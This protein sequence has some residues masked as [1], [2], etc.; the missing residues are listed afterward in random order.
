MEA[1]SLNPSNAS[2][3]SIL[4][5]VKKFLKASL[6][7]LIPA[8]ASCGGGS[9]SP[10]PKPG[11]LTLEVPVTKIALQQNASATVPLTITR[12][13]FDGPV[14][15]KFVNA[16]ASP[17]PAWLQ[18]DP[19]QIAAGATTGTLTLRASDSADLIRNACGVALIATSPAS[20]S[21]YARSNVCVQVTSAVKP[22]RLDTGFADF[23]AAS[24]SEA[25]DLEVGQNDD[26]FVLTKKD[27]QKLKANGQVD[28]NFGTQGAVAK[29]FNLSL[30][31][32]DSMVI[33]PNNKLV[34]VGTETLTG[35]IQTLSLA[36]YNADGSLDSTFGASGKAR[37]SGATGSGCE[38]A[39]IKTLEE[40][41]VGTDG[42]IRAIGNCASKVVVITVSA[43]GVLETSYGQSGY[44]LIPGASYGTYG[45]SLAVD[46][47]GRVV[48]A[49]NYLGN[50]SGMIVSRFTTAG[51]L[52]TTFDTDGEV[53]P[54]FGITGLSATLYPVYHPAPTAGITDVSYTDSV[55]TGSTAVTVQPDGKI[56][57]AATVNS[58]FFGVVRL[59]DTGA[60][61]PSFGT[62][63]HQAITAQGGVAPSF[64]EDVVLQKD[65]K[66]LI[67]GLMT[68]KANFQFMALVRLGSNGQ[69]D[70]TFNG[71]GVSGYAG[72]YSSHIGL[73]SAR[74][75]GLQSNGQI[76]LAGDL[77]TAR[78]FP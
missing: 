3:M 41:T 34:V 15:I 57:V 73:G 38:E 55:L 63:G 36:Q 17:L 52:D 49:S 50:R 66:I 20:E 46:S 25:I 37:F 71:S 69:P 56:L 44:A 19:V 47:A 75:I 70:A 65:N 28:T 54:D 8:L 16:D 72:V 10:T 31:N 23:G 18:A 14:N 60:P 68:P 45:K 12:T 7:I 24:I 58:K 27:I 4:G 64:V 42:K 43:T 32:T 78:L 6:W 40:V 30:E 53:A 67:S 1:W 22:G 2:F 61:D 48:V 26:L 74:A 11:K 13:D 51:R 39:D 9:T 59:L 76:I 29:P 33:T 77:V 62:N 5:D 21:A 35:N